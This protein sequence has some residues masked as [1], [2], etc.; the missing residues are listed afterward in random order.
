LGQYVDVDAVGA[1]PCGP[2]RHR[3]TTTRTRG[4][5]GPL[6]RA[7]ICAP[8]LCTT[9][10]YP[11]SAWSPTCT[12][13]VPKAVLQQRLNPQI[14]PICPR[15]VSSRRPLLDRPLGMPKSEIKLC[16]G[17]MVCRFRVVQDLNAKYC[18]GC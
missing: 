14:G 16:T 12:G 8:R 5:Q 17:F 3:G 15:R 1:L 11:W 7:K 4:A 9:H 10:A 18:R 13:R 6:R 2:A